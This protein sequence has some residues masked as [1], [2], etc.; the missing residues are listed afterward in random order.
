MIQKHNLINL[1]IAGVADHPPEYVMYAVRNDYPE[2]LSILNKGIDSISKEELE[3]IL[4]KW[5]TVKV[6][7]K[8]D[9]SE[10]W[11]WIFVISGIFIAVLGISLFWN[12]RL[13]REISERRQIE[14]ALLTE[15]SNLKALLDSAPVGILI[16]DSEYCVMKANRAA[17]QLFTEKSD[18]SLNLRCG[19]LIACIHRHE[20]P[21]GCG[22]S[23]HCRSCPMMNALKRCIEDGQR[24]EGEEMEACLDNGQRWLRFSVNNVIIEGNLCAVAA[25][26]DITDRKTAEET[27]RKSEMKYRRLIDLATSIVLEWDS[28][29]T[30][31]FINRYGLEFF[32][33]AENE[34]LGRNVVG[35]II[36]QI[37]LSG[38]DLQEKMLRVRQNPDAYHSSENENIRKNGERVWIAWTN[39]GIY[40]DNGQLIKTLS[41]GIDRTRQ[42]EAE[43]YLKQNEARLESILRI[44]QFKG[45]TVK[46][47]LDYALD[48][49]IRLTGSRI[50]YIYYYNEESKEFTLNTWSEEVMKECCVAKPQTLYH[51][52]KTGIWGEAVRQRRPII[53]NEFQAPHPLKKG[54]PEGHAVLYKFLTVPVFVEGNIVAVIGLANKKSDYDSSDAAQLLM[55]MDSVWNIA[56][57]KRAEEELIKA[58]ETAESA[59]RAKSEFLASMSHEIRTPMNTIVNM[60][61]TG[62]G[63]EQICPDGGY[64]LGYSAFSD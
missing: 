24:T 27:L 3:V 35:T 29:G 7:H 40:G 62:F 22:Y 16:V 18:Q 4:Q 49:A 45:D 63:T 61:Q 9:W 23:E 33:F 6:E 28:R 39:K 56:D 20:H 31:L 37:D 36:P 57:R 41:I 38:D 59:T 52:D 44:S 53:L 47:L 60:S 10:I 8:A 46:E 25:L 21:R 30:V 32:G 11:H 26:D 14:K 15:R 19:I 58:K 50:G 1:R 17:G 2:L 54:Y 64:S 34:I 13:A 12:R 42:K 48:E 43:E 55:L 51:L 5:F